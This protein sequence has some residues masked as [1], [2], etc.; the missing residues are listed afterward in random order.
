MFKNNLI[1]NIYETRFIAS[2]I[3]AGG[4][5]NGRGA[6]KD[7]KEWLK[8]LGLT[9]D[10]VNHIAYIAT[11]GKLELEYNAEQFLKRKGS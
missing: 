11:N 8:S 5:I 6:V 9:D 4:K 3:I 7:F 10:Q 1:G 2:W